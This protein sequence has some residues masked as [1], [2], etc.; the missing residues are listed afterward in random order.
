MRKF[1]VLNLLIVSILSY[2]IAPITDQMLAVSNKVI[3]TLLPA[4]GVTQSSSVGWQRLAYICGLFF[5][6]ISCL[7]DIFD[8][9]FW[10]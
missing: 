2:E 1:V 8:R 4:S 5:P 7:I 6:L 10:S 9:Y 3:E